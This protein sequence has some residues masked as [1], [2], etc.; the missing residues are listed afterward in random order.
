MKRI[1]TLFLALTLLGSLSAC[2]SN[3][4]IA[5]TETISS[6]GP[7]AVITVKDY[8]EIRVQLAPEAAP[9]TVDNFVSLAEAGFYDGLTFHRIISG[10]MIQGGD[11][12]GTG[13][14]GSDKTIQGEF[15]EN[16]IENPISHKRGT[17]SMARSR[18]MDS[19][20]SQFFICHED[21]PHL[22]GA[23]AGFGQ[24]IS[25]MDV[26]D[27]ICRDTEVEDSNGTVR[28]ENQPVIQ[29]VVIED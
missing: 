17:I 10:F 22:D 25:G 24:V 23:Y 11:P 26:V 4:S 2:G 13:T 12:L 8:G 18:D 27:A 3:D 1:L 15:R 7:V 20:S 14:G 16:G 5:E 28:K 29:S 6:E 19:A 9:I 21:S